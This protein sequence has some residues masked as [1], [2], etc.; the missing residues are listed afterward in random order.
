MVI[1]KEE[2]QRRLNSQKNFQA[3]LDQRVP[4]KPVV[5][6]QPKPKQVQAVPAP[7]DARIVAGALAATG[8]PQKTIAR[9]FGLTTNQVQKAQKLPEVRSTVERVKEIALDKLMAS[10][11]LMTE[12]KF[13]NS[14]LKDLS[15]VAA[16]LSR[17]VER[18]TPQENNT[19]LQLIVYAPE[20]KTERSYKVLD[21]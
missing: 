6:V 8:V 15:A 17:V 7:R 12:D 9:E 5:K 19:T 11:N 16:N 13:E 10:L 18:T 1:S 3:V 20:Q 4:Q 2:L 14:S 21:V